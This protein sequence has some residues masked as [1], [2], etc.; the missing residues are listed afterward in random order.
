VDDD[1][2]PFDDR[3][4]YLATTQGAN[5]ESAGLWETAD[6]GATWE[7]VLDS[8]KLN[9]LEGRKLYPFLHSNGITFHPKRKGWVYYATGTHGLWLTKDAGR[10]WKRFAGIPRLTVS[11]IFFDPKDPDIIYACS[12]G[13]WKGPAEGY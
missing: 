3:H 7:H 2:D 9:A 4:I 13:L 10:T 12:V 6:G 5:R 8:G 11:K 1:I